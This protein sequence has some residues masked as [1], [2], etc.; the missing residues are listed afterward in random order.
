MTAVLSQPKCSHV[1]CKRPAE[2]GLKT[3][4]ECR[5]RNRAHVKASRER[6]RSRLAD[7]SLD[8]TWGLCREIDEACERFLMRRKVNALVGRCTCA[9]NLRAEPGPGRCPICNGM[10]GCESCGKR[11]PENRWCKIIGALRH[12]WLCE[13][14]RHKRQKRA[15]RNRYLRTSTRT[16][17]EIREAKGVDPE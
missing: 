5:D 15:N 11:K 6:K 9:V 8:L 13:R 12:A 3:C 7:C 10:D 4:R 17:F 14:C 1:W 2:H 16:P